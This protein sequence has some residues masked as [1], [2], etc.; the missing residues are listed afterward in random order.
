M[1]FRNGV[2]GGYD[3]TCMLYFFTNGTIFIIKV[4]FNKYL[5]KMGPSE[6]S[7][8][9]SWI[10][11]TGLSI[12][13]PGVFKFSLHNGKIIETAIWDSLLWVLKYYSPTF[14]EGKNFVL[15]FCN[16]VESIHCWKRLG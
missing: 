12:Q 15:V 4:K 8:L 7:T 13:D 16:S 6:T 2:M 11:H 3:S 5:L 10:K 9:V 1:D 14:A